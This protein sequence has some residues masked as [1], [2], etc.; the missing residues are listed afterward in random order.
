MRAVQFDR[1]GPP[2]VL[3]VAE[4][5]DVHPGPGQVRIRVRAAGVNPVDWKIRNGSSRRA[6]PVELPSIPG[7]EAAG[8]VDELGADVTGVRVGDHVFGS[9]VSGASAELALLDHWAAKP[10]AMSWAE[11]GGLSMAVETAARGLDA[12]GDL[13]GRTLLVSG[14]AGGVGT[15]AV[16]LALSRGAEVVATAGADN[17]EYLAGLGARA[18]TYGPGLLDRVRTLAPEGVDLALDVAGYD[19]LPDLITL[20]GGAEHVLTLIDPRAAELDVRFSTG[21]EGRAFYALDVVADLFTQGRFTMPVAGSFGLDQLAEAHR[22]SESGHLRGKLV[23]E[24]P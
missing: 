23:V 17:Q 3:H 22:V 4:V 8:E 10:D 24:L 15:A 2:E 20:T 21:S 5:P 9:V 18:T 12:L 7:L 16:Q 1:T 11:A 6:I 13:T 14:A 19:V